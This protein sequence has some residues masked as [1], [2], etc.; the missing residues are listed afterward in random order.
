MNEAPNVSETHLPRTEPTLFST[1]HP[2]ALPLPGAEE[3][4]SRST[5]KQ[6]SPPPT[7]PLKIARTPSPAPYPTQTVRGTHLGV[8]TCIHRQAGPGIARR[9]NRIGSTPLPSTQPHSSRKGTPL[10]AVRGTHPG[11]LTCIH[12][13][14]GP[15]IARRGN[16]VGRRRSGPSCG[17]RCVCRLPRSREGTGHTCT[18]GIVK[19]SVDTF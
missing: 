15:G 19:G 12:R 1:T 14:A 16:R 18:E 8:L 11:V 9:G 13:R 7:Y 10:W 5:G 4:F 3:G 17:S 6:G 2:N